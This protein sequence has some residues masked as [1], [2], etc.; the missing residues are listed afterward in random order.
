MTLT[1]LLAV[2]AL[3]EK[4][5]VCAVMPS[6]SV[7]TTAPGVEFSGAKFT[8]CCGGCSGPFKKD[9]AKFLKQA[10]DAGNVIGTSLFD[11]VSRLRQDPS[12]AVAWSDYKGVRFHF[13]SAENKAT[14]DADPTKYGTIPNKE[15]LVCAVSGETVADYG[16]SA[17]YADHNGVRYYACCA[18]CMAGLQKDIAELSKGPKVKVT[19]PKAIAGK[20]SVPHI[21]DGSH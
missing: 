17:G 3:E 11:P 15:S 10:S 5:V 6:H 2:V 18:G 14:F 21:H 1:M 9:P 19:A 12:K 7:K 20:N 16:T 13:A 4:P 8:F